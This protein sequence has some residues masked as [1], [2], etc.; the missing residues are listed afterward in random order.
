MF[1]GE[2]FNKVYV[3]QQLVTVH[4]KTSAAVNGIQ[5]QSF[6]SNYSAN[7]ASLHD[8]FASL[9]TRFEVMFVDC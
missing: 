3:V 8:I 5:K 2:C 9:P 4:S 6:S 7:K 1:E